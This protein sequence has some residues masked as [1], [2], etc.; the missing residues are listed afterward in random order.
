[1]SPQALHIQ[2]L[3]FQKPRLLGQREEASGQPDALRWLPYRA[4]CPTSLPRIPQGKCS[5]A[6]SLLGPPFSLTRTLWPVLGM[7]SIFLSQPWALGP[8]LG[9]LRVGSAHSSCHHPSAGGFLWGV[10]EQASCHLVLVP[11]LLCQ[12]VEHMGNVGQPSPPIQRASICQPSPWHTLHPQ[13]GQLPGLPEGCEVTLR[14]IRVHILVKSGGQSRSL[15]GHLCLPLHQTQPSP[16]SLAPNTQ[17][18]GEALL[19]PLI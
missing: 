2:F 6:G 9:H 4:L 10:G 14:H 5:G 1:M 11:Q 12:A 3:R 8:A 18:L 13:E 15:S 17:S 7:R 16:S 19:Q